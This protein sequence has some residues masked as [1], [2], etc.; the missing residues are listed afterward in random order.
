MPYLIIT[1][2]VLALAACLYYR[3]LYVPAPP[4]YSSSGNLSREII[5]A[6]GLERNYLL[7][8]P[9]HLAGGQA[10]A[11]IVLHGSNING[12]KIRAWTGY[13]FDRLADR[14]GFQVIYPDAIAGH[15]NDIRK[16]GTYRSKKE[17]IDDVGFIKAL[18]NK[19][20][21]E[22]NNSVYAFGYSNGGVMLYRLIAECPG[23]FNAIAIVGANL[24]VR[25]NRVVEL[26]GAAPTVMLVSG[27]R[28]PIIPYDGGTVK[29]FGRDLGQVLSA[30][31]TG[32]YFARSQEA[33]KKDDGRWLVGISTFDHTRVQEENWLKRGDVKVK[34]YTIENGGHVIPSAH[35]VFPGLMGRITKQFDAVE[36]AI[37]FFGLDKL[38]DFKS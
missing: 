36:G 25:E 9:A 30:E 34:L 21:V 29:L 16:G 19:W 2:L 37:S 31:E 23:L 10:P 14:Y 17:N 3:W 35:A 27:T 15:W 4:N 20:R 5:S 13:D 28:D 32:N 22:P 6:G 38:N 7:Y 8:T 11:V 1:V 33:T 24:P 12:G 26:S 18:A